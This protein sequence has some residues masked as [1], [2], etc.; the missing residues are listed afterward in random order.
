MFESFPSV[1]II[2]ENAARAA[3]I[4]AGLRTAGHQH[5]TIIHEMHGIAAIIESL[6]PDV[7]VIDLEN[8]NR[9]RLENIFQLARAVKRPIAM[10]VDR[11]DNQT[12]QSA[13]DAGV[14]AYVVDGLKQERVKNIL[15][16]AISRF[17][18]YS[19]LER[20]LEEARGALASRKIIDQAKRL[21]MTSRGLDE[22]AAYKLLRKAAMDQNRK[23]ADVAQGLVTAAGLLITPTSKT[24]LEN[25]NDGGWHD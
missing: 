22:D 11:S 14:S 21:I 5:V 25:S 20:E 1:L 17:N 15:D 18:A 2:D 8:P 12:M 23:V 3:I 16:M 9:D 4:E 13:I 6:A 7:I 10:F 19:R 24:K